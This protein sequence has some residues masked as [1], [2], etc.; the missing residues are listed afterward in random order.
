MLAELIRQNELTAVSAL[1][2]IKYL[3]I[4]YPLD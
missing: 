2:L 3:L 1:S 4:I